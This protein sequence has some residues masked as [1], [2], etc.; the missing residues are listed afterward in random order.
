MSNINEKKIEEFILHW[1]IDEM[2]PQEQVEIFKEE[3]GVLLNELSP[4]QKVLDFTTTYGQLVADKPSLP[5]ATL[6]KLR[7]NL[8]KEEYQEYIDGEKNNDLVAIADALA[9]MIYIIVGTAITY[10]IPLYDV[11]N[12]VHD[13]NM[14]KLDDE[15]KP[16]YREDGKILKGPNY[17]PP[18]I[19]EILE[20]Q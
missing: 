18:R 7:K 11:F 9:D 14:S 6:R 1:R 13:S 19:K 2:L 12:E 8:I 20:R 3:L 4:F 17:F 5:S 16:I 15:G 10:G